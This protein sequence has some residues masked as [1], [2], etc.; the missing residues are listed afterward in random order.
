MAKT[1]CSQFRGP[2]FSP[3]QGT[4][5]HILQ[6]KSMQAT[7]K[8]QCSQINKYFLKMSMRITAPLQ[9]THFKDQAQRPLETLPLMG[10]RTCYLKIWHLGILTIF[11][12][13]TLRKHAQEGLFDLPLHP[14]SR[15]WDP[16]IREVSLPLKTEGSRWIQTGPVCQQALQSTGSWLPVF[17][18]LPCLIFSSWLSTLH[19]T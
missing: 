16:P 11:S 15:S 2:G 4:R 3:G 9:A 17:N 13:R 14:W 5:S 18:H 12:W 10:F 1:S 8:T 7:M 6:L 19:Q